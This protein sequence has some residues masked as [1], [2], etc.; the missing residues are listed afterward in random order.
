M[1]EPNGASRAP[2]RFRV[3]DEDDAAMR[4]DRLQPRSSV[5]IAAAED[6]ADDAV[7]ERTRG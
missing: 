7:P 2:P 5:P 6:D 3:L 4:S 1:G